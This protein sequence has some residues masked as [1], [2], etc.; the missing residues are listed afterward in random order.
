M[1]L[2]GARPLPG[3]NFREAG[4]SMFE[5]PLLEGSAIAVIADRFWAAKQARDRLKIEW[6]L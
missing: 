2:P 5:I 6:D 4:R 3:S 1:L